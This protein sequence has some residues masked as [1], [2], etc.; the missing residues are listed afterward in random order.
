MEEDN[1]IPKAYTAFT[2]TEIEKIAEKTPNSTIDVIGIISKCED[3]N[4]VSIKGES[5]ERR[6]LELVDDSNVR[7]TL[8]LWGSPLVLRISAV[9]LGD[10]IALRQVR[11]GDFN[12]RS[13]TAS[14]MIEDIF[15]DVR[16]A[17]KMDLQ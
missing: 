5:K 13:L 17:R 9:K 8:T 6:T 14:D 3:K 12:G 15:T 11:V 10:I 2:F 7:V 4:E 1:L 16:H